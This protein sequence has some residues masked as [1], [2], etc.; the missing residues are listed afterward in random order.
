MK[1]EVFIR[2]ERQPPFKAVGPAVELAGKRLTGPL[3]MPH[4][5]V[6]TVGTH[7]V[8]GADGAVFAPH[9]QQRRATDRQILDKIITRLEE[10]LLPSHVEPHATKNPFA[11]QR[12]VLR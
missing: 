10:L 7:V 5:F 2:D 4:Q 6:A 9:H 12:K 11:L 1:E 8:K 3:S